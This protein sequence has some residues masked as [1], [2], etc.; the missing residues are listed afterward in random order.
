MELAIPEKRIGQPLFLGKAKQRFDLRAD[1]HLL[2]ALI[3]ARHECD[4]RKLFDQRSIAQV[5]L[6]AV[7]VIGGNGTSIRRDDARADHACHLLQ[8]VNGLLLLG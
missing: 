3:E 1:V 5:R 8:K 4:D 7:A 6:P 2:H